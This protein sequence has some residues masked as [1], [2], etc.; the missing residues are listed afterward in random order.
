LL[1]RGAGLRRLAL[2]GLVIASLAACSGAPGGSESPREPPDFAALHYTCANFPV[3]AAMLSAPARHDEDA[4]T[5]I[6][7]ALR[8]HLARPAPNNAFFP[9]T[10]W[11]LAWQS[12]HA[13]EFILVE[14]DLRLKM[15][16]VDD[17]SG[18]WKV[19][20]WGDCLPQLVLA[21]GLGLAGWEWGGAGEPTA[22][23]TAFDALVTEL[24]CASGQSAEGRIVGPQIVRATDVVL[25]VFAVRPRPGGQDCQGNPST[26]VPVN[27][28]EPLGD[29]ELI[30]GGRLRPANPSSP[31]PAPAG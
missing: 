24:A 11:T 31:A 3:T 20:G 15:V 10:G 23:T 9:K 5:Q 16:H 28:G 8:E 29:R 12:E 27:I 17:A 7:A 30:D 25:V 14:G 2:A 21:E 19:G 18:P 4:D 26:R 13:A 22:G 1:V 6:A